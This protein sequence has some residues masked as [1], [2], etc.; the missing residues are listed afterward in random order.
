MGFFQEKIVTQEYPK[1]GNSSLL[2]KFDDAQFLVF[3]NRIVAL[4]L[5]GTYLI[6]D[7]HRYLSVTLVMII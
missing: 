4:S 7:W 2:K 3:A 1:I 6:Y 5:S